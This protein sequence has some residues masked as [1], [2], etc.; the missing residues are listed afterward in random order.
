MKKLTLKQQVEED[1]K[2]WEKLTKLTGW[3]VIGF[4]YRQTA[5]FDTGSRAPYRPGFQITGKELDDILAGVSKAVNK[6]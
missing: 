5:S 3:R 2:Y 1:H 6:R 4:S